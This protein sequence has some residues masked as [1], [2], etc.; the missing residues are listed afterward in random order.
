MKYIVA[1]IFS[2]KFV[3]KTLKLSSLDFEHYLREETI[4][5]NT[6]V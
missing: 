3:I 2:L 4:R 1:A 6:V 5:G